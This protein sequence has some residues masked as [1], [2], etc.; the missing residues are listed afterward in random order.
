M[1][2]NYQ[3]FSMYTFKYNSAHHVVEYIRR[4]EMLSDLGNGFCDHIIVRIKRTGRRLSKKTTTYVRKHKREK[5]N[6]RE[7]ASIQK[8]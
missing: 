4:N 2:A 3:K 1:S 6:I 5:R 7:N 8:G